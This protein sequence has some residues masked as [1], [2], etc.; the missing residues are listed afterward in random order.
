M[1]LNLGESLSSASDLIKSESS[2]ETDFTNEFVQAS[3]KDE[4]DFIVL[5]LALKKPMCGTE[6]MKAVLGKFGL[7]LS[8]GTI[9]PLLHSLEKR[10]LLEHE[11]SG[12][13][14]TYK[15]ARGK[16]EKIRR[17]LEERISV[18]LTLIRFLKFAE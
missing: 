6:I 8:P 18:K 17:M 3:A 15:P 16:E 4:L 10:G 11:H 9:Y 7:L 5:A 13:A 1:S 14:K 12:K 2:G